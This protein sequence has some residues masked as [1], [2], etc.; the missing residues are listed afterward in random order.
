MLKWFV[1]FMILYGLWPIDVKFVVCFSLRLFLPTAI[2][3]IYELGHHL[4]LR[5]RIP[6]N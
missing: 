3:T 6:A 4:E 5:D 2:H 1:I